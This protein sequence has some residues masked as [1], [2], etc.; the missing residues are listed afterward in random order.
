MP[1]YLAKRVSNSLNKKP[2]SPE[3]KLQKALEEVA[4]DIALI[5][6]DVKDWEWWISYLL[7]HLEDEAENR[8]KQRDYKEMLK[9]LKSSFIS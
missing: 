3:D 7:E 1:D 2:E 9:S 5:E 4:R 8:R 6:P